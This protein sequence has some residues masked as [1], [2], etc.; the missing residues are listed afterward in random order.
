MNT[1]WWRGSRAPG[2]VF[3]LSLIATFEAWHLSNHYVEERVGERFNFRVSQVVDA[4]NGRMR[5]YE[6]VLRGGVGLFL[7]S[8]TVTQRQ[9]HEYVEN[10]N[11]PEH[12]PGIQNMAIDF[13]IP[14]AEKEAHIASMRALGYA[15]YSIRPEQPERPVYHTLA[16]VEP[17]GGR[18]LRAF[19]FDMYTNPTR[20]VAMERAIEQGVPAISG[21]VLLAQETHQDVQQGFIFCLPVY[22]QCRPAGTLAERH[23]ALRALVCGAFRANDLMRGIFGSSTNDVELEIFDDGVVS[24]DT[25]LYTSLAKD[26]LVPLSLSNGRLVEVGGRKWLLR[27]SANQRFLDSVSTLQSHVIALAGGFF[28]LALLITFTS[29]VGRESKARKLASEM[30]AQI[31]ENEKRLA[32]V[33]RRFELAADSASIGVWDYSIVS[34]ALIWDKRMYQLFQVK[35]D[36]FER[37]Y[38]A[39]SS[40][41]HPEDRARAEAELQAAI[42]GGKDFDTHFRIVWKN[43]EVRNIKAYARLELDSAGQPVRMTGINY[44]ITEQ[45]AMEAREHERTEQINAIFALSPDGFVVFD[46]SGCVRFVSPAFMHLTGLDEAEVMGLNETLFAARL[47]RACLPGAVFPNLMA[48]RAREQMIGGSHR[49]LIEIAGPGKRVLEAGLR[50]SRTE[51][52]SQILYFR[53]I[54]HETEVE[55]IKNEF[56]STAA[57][58]LRTPMASIYGYTEIL[59]TQDFDEETRRELLEIIFHNSELI[60]AIINELLDLSRI[61]ARRGKDFQLERLDLALLLR[62]IVAHFKAPAGRPILSAPTSDG[63][64]QV[65]ADRQKLTQAVSNVLSNAYKYSPSGGEVTLDLVES[66]PRIG[67]RV[68]DQG[69]GM[70]PQQIERVCERF[71]RADA[72]GQILGTGLGM[73]IVKEIIELHGGTVA[74]DSEPGLGTRVTLWIPMSDPPGA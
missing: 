48:L 17:F 57:H 71:Y 72:S 67:I 6:Q 28:N 73:S 70:T 53:D 68:T 64:R 9:W 23:A 34:G 39:W 22:H 41:L 51:T 47:A 8:P 2:A 66:P 32:E 25:R 16:Y 26:S 74:I 42:A 46:R 18:N 56:L 54:T 33:N 15:E 5:D 7:A 65:R 13:P 29:L 59:L 24:P 14:A 3:L 20:R 31:R 50:L 37:T 10:A 11:M 49:E 35:P 30:T 62:E 60:I 45:R 61:E 4:V 43:G 38:N 12:Y 58:E 40:R 36:E 63:T 55:Q 69:I 44:D 27:I 1:R 19:G 52:V 21:M